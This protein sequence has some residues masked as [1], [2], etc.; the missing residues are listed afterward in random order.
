MKKR[1]TPWNLTLQLEFYSQIVA[2]LRPAYN[3]LNLDRGR[4]A[5]I[6]AFSNKIACE[7]I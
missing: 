3:G 2:D 5:F 6:K 7:E 4:S 1:V